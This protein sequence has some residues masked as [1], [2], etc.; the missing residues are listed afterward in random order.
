MYPLLRT[1]RA[2]DDF[3]DG[4]ASLMRVNLV[5]IFPTIHSA[6]EILFLVLK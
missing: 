2:V 6:L 5:G 3:T 4:A 1:L